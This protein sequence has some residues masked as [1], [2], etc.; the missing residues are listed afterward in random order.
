MGRKQEYAEEVLCQKNKGHLVC[1]SDL[2]H[3]RLLGK[4]VAELAE[5][6]P[7]GPDTEAELG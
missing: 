3:T 6:L 5:R 4:S 7:M 2:G 1:C